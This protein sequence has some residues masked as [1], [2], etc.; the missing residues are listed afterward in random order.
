[1]EITRITP[2]NQDARGSISD[3]LAGQMFDAATI[4][5]SR[6]G[7]VRGN[8]YHKDTI[9]WT[10]LLSGRLL[11]AAWREGHPVE[12]KEV[13][14]GEL[15][16]HDIFEA[17]SVKAIEPSVFLVLTRGPRSGEDYESDTY[18]LATPLQSSAL[19]T[20]DAGD[21]GVVPVNEPLIG[22]ATSRYVQEC[23]TTGWI[24]SEGRFIQELERSW[25]GW[26][27][28][29][30]G[31]AVC[32][33]T[34]ALEI[35]C[36]ALDLRPGD[37]VIMPSFT[38]ISCALAILEAG[39]TPV[40]VDSD[41]VT[42]CLDV[43]QVRARVT[44]RTRA[45]MP[46][47]MYGH[48]AEMDEVNAIAREH[49][50]D[51][52]ED[53]AEAHGALYRGRRVGAFGRF[54][55][56]SFY[57]NKIVTT[58]EGGMVLCHTEADAERLRSLRNLCF[59]KD[60]RFW[61]TELGHNFRM[62]NMQAAVGVAQVE[63]IDEHIR[64]KKAMAAF[65]GER[66]SGLRGVQLPAE[67][68]HVSSVFW[69]YGLVLDEAFPLDAR[70]FADE[71]RA[72]GVETRPFFVGMHEQPVFRDRG[73]FLGETYPVAERLAREGFYLPSGLTLS[74]AQMER[75]CDGVRKVHG[76]FDG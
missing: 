70:Q 50:L 14:P 20:A 61:H 24:S 59:K 51:V 29:E 63:Q 2:A 11:V 15:V 75:V 16:R 72:L 76:R 53:A 44:P 71:L 56:F 8:H 31:V 28:A 67:L 43:E 60:R 62:T 36:Q 30:Y 26:C 69:M 25:A 66:L 10:Y 7:A 13:Q 65:Y 73:L 4:I 68:P 32:N 45:I 9:Q 1:M 58:G 3:I 54:G 34:A 21:A 40:L 48:P 41:P 39:A 57:A 64:R 18:R 37:E 6:P 12:E 35:A 46:V 17:H 55:T 52:I 19:A 49:G 27:G 22:E 74:V 47:H 5:E 38:I 23:L 33:G 42:W